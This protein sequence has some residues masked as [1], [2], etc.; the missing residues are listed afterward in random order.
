MNRMR[1]F[2]R[3]RRE[4][5]LAA[6]EAS[7]LAGR[8]RVRGADAGLH[9]LLELDTQW[10]DETLAARARE[11]GIRLSFLSEYGG[12]EAH[13]LVVRDPVGELDH[14]AEALERLA[15]LL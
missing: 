5:L 13:C 14:W 6:L 1:V 7:S 4:R 2:Y 15:G 8:C 11:M 10:D 9:F 12:G 3:A